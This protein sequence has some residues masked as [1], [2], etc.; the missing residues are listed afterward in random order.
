[1]NKECKKCNEVKSLRHF[2]QYSQRGVQ[3]YETSCKVCRLQE[4]H[5][6]RNADIY[7]LKKYGITPQEKAAL[8]TICAICGSTYMLCIDHDHKTNK[9]CGR[10]CS[11]CN[12]AIG[13]F[14][15]DAALL[16]RAAEYVSK[17]GVINSTTL[18]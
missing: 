4:M 18:I 8:G 6:K 3:Y 12:K 11:K 5:S 17:S 15:D 13:L 10:L 7:V 14:S 1:M 16:K 9:V 2:Y